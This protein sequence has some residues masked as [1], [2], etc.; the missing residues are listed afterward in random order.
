VRFLQRQNIINGGS[1]H[2]IHN[3]KDTDSE[4]ENSFVSEEDVELYIKD[5]EVTIN[6]S[7]S[8]EDDDAEKEEEA[9]LNI[10]DERELM[11]QI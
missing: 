10:E 2:N 6:V 9:L 7:D 11:V 1:T 8:S 3:P 4:S 5:E